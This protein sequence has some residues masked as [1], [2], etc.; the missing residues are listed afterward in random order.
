M[1]HRF[2]PCFS[3]A[4][5]ISVFGHAS[6]THS[7]KT[8]VVQFS[9]SSKTFISRAMARRDMSPLLCPK[10]AR[11]S[12]EIGILFKARLTACPAAKPTESTLS[13]IHCMTVR[14]ARN[15]YSQFFA[16]QAHVCI[17]FALFY[18]ERHRR[19]A[20][21]YAFRSIRFVKSSTLYLFQ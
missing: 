14:C 1:L 15:S 13:G 3:S 2:M 19:C 5:S 21:V 4:A 11:R 12:F 18:P 20:C 17:C 8:A 6:G 10:Y 7:L 16:E 9:M